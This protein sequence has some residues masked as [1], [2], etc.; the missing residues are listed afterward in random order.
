MLSA[1]RM[2]ETTARTIAIAIGSGSIIRQLQ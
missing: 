2:T 1:V